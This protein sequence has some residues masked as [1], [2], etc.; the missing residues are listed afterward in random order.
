VEL[1]SAYLRKF[2]DEER[3][4]YGEVIRGQISTLAN[5]PSL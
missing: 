4:R 3:L 5:F 1:S 2:V